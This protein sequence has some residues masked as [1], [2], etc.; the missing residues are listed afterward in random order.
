MGRTGRAGRTA[1]AVLGIG[2]LTAG[3]SVVAAS[4]AA[5]EPA[6]VTTTTVSPTTTTTTTVTTTT[7]TPDGD[8][9]ALV[10]E[11]SSGSGR[12]TPDRGTQLQ[13]TPTDPPPPTTTT[14]PVPAYLQLPVDSGE[15]RRIVYHKSRQRVWVVEADG[16]V[17]R[18]HAVSGRLSLRSPS[19]G[20][21]EVFSRS[22]FTC[23]LKNP[24]I[25]WRYMV[26]FA[27]GPNGDNI[28]LHEIPI[29]HATGRPVQSTSQLGQPLSGGCV[30]QSTA[31][32]Q[33]IWDWA[34]VGTK[35]VVIQ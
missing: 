33:F 35:V 12:V 18:T 21:Y 24:N 7:T 13:V 8:E 4:P 5:I 2:L 6:A 11:V 3:T 15:G 23:N 34:P 27:K 28:G 14:I 16:T 30:R 1:S 20:T 26:R 17:V 25:C 29:N 19:A 32:A 10:A 9:P 31:S 22:K